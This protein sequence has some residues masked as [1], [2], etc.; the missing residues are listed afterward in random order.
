M[1][2][3]RKAREVRSSA[4]VSAVAEV[5]PQADRL[6]R[7]APWAVGLVFF[8]AYALTT[9]RTVPGGDSGELITVARN[10]GVAHPPGYPL[11]TLLG[12]LFSWIPF[13]TVAWRVNLLSGACDAVA[14]GLLVY[15]AGRWAKNV[16][17]GVLAGGLFAGSPLVWR[18]AT[19]AEVFALNNLFVAALVTLAVLFDENPRPKI[20][21]LGS[22]LLGLGL[23]NHQSLAFYGLP[24][25]LWVS[26]RGRAE[27]MRPA[28]LL[29]LL[30]LFV[31]GLVPYVY[32]ALAGPRLTLSTWGDTGTW[33]GFW[34]HVLR[35]EYGTFQLAANTV[36]R[37]TR[38]SDGLWHYAADLPGQLLYVG[39]VLA[40]VGVWG[41]LKREGPAGLGAVTLVA[42]LF[43]MLVFH[44]LANLPL[45][46]GLYFDVH[47]R[48]WQQANL[49]VAAWAGLG[50]V[51]ALEWGRT[52]A[53]R[54]GPAALLL[55]AVQGG[56]QFF[57]EDQSHNRTFL[58]L[59][60]SLLE[61]L[62]EGA[63]LLT[64]GDVYFNSTRYLQ[65]VEGVR[66]DVCV[67]DR[68]MVKAVWLARLVARHC[69]G[70]VLPKGH[71]GPGEPDG[72]NL[73]EFFDANPKTAIYTSGFEKQDDRSWEES[74]VTFPFGLLNYVVPKD[75][76]IDLPTY[77]RLSDS[78]LSAFDPVALGKARK[79]S[80]EDLLRA[81]YWEAD[82]RRARR[83][84]TY[85]EKTGDLA[86]LLKAVALMESLLGRHPDP[87][88]DLHKNLGTG[89]SRL[90]P[91]D[92]SA[93]PKMVSA[94]KKYLSV[95]PADDSDLTTIRTAIDFYDKR[96]TGNP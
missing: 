62:P 72:Y 17:A 82:H 8:I 32:V 55:V 34:A 93:A 92:P 12:H 19:V 58:E 33:A 70:V 81:D 3:R 6:P 76:P 88:A 66:P 47:S 1:G 78:A 30:A 31:A 7:L 18:Y 51:W 10:L 48:F 79:N 77:L 46:V 4:R 49:L 86:A 25:V 44:G 13:G 26:Y 22:F 37:P 89:Y 84:M 91:T 45:D 83:L 60:R 5:S 52:H 96:A 35:R 80:W 65:Q 73:K 61:P 75:R 28:R 59:G 68:E 11:Y 87:P 2:K 56:V 74:Y 42:F 20:A 40:G 71:F 27:L 14:A 67:L 90:I 38:L 15:A 53:V 69:P 63:L 23:S 54:Y 95:A 41:A 36:G 50:F 39:P 64:K 24:L 85:A 21:Y 29:L 9:C 94:W 57:R 43:Y 16:W